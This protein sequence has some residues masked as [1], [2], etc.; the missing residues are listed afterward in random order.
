MHLQQCGQSA[1]KRYPTHPLL[2]ALCTLAL[3]NGLRLT[4][5]C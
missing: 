5:K 2:I 1:N 3:Q 4:G